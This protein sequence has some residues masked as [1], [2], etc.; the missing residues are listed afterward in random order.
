MSTPNNLA[1]HTFPIPHEHPKH[2]NWLHRFMPRQRHE[3][4]EEDRRARWTVAIVLF[5]AMGF[6]LLM[7]IA[8]VL[9]LGLN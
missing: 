4:V 1:P 6:G 2:P 7:L 8:T 5:S 3:L 9:G